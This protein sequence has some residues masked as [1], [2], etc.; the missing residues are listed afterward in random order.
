[1]R[2]SYSRFRNKLIWRVASP[3][4]M[5]EVCVAHRLASSGE[6]RKHGSL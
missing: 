5:V 2:S 3:M 1:M 6:I 4:N